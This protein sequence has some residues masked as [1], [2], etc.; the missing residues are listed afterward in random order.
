MPSNQACSSVELCRLKSLSLS[1]C[2]CFSVAGPANGT[3]GYF[4][5]ATNSKTSYQLLVK[6]EAGY[7]GPVTVNVETN[8]YA[9][10][11]S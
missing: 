4:N 1:T 10:C 5:Y 9:R 7:L 11:L 6:W 3:V 8:R 2:D